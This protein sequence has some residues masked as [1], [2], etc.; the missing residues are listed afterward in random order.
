[1]SRLIISSDSPAGVT[2]KPSECLGVFDSGIGG[3]A[4]AS[5]ILRKSPDLPLVYIADQFNAPYGVRS[6]SDVENLAFAITDEL[7]RLGAATVT[8]ACNTASAAALYSLRRAFHQIEIVGMEPAIK[9]AA[10]DTYS[11]KIG[12]IAT[13]NTLRGEPYAGVMTRYAA[14]LKVHALACPEF[15]ELV[16]NGE[17]DSA[18]ARRT[19]EKKLEPLLAEGIDKLVLGCTH[20]YFL[21]H[22]IEEVCRGRASVVD[23]VQAVAD[24][25]LRVWRRL[26]PSPEMESLGN[27]SKSRFI[28]TTCTE[29]RRK[30]F[31]EAVRR[32]VKKDTEIEKGVWV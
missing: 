30:V 13:E 15:V 18:N 9:P 21:I 20:Y 14:D 26:Y 25:T 7:V 11:G 16:E 8:L 23:P 24:Q 6:F 3:L 22:L 28:T 17:I 10:R 4:V 2:G 31:Q 12:V 29:S 27:G 19:V 5:H 1:M 32:F